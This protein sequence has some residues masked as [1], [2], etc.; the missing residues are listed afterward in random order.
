MARRCIFDGGTPLTTEH[1]IPLWVH[2]YLPGQGDLRYERVG[3][4]QGWTSDALA[5]TLRRV[6]ARCNG[7]WMSRLEG[8]AKPLL[9][10]VIQD[11]PRVWT[12]RE[13]R[14]VATW[15]FKTAILGGLATGQAH[16]P[17]AHFRHLARNLH[18][19]GRVTIWTTVHLP[20][21]SE[22]D[23]QV[24][25]FDARGLLFEGGSFGKGFHGYTLTVNVGHFAFQVLGH[26]SREHLDLNSPVIQG[27]P[28]SGYEIRIWP[29]QGRSVSWPPK[30]GFDRSGLAFYSARWLSQ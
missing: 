23:F 2:G 11:R 22:T 16:V 6:C 20:G 9:V 17:E 28:P 12:P 1:V 21:P 7:G 8:R 14:T 15:A 29:V 18:P 5:V 4:R 30:R 13:Q 3:S 19:P 25:H 27:I 26:E 24:A 10:D